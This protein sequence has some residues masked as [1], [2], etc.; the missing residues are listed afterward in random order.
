MGG[1][2]KCDIGFTVKGF[3]YTSIGGVV[4][5]CVRGCLV[6]L[7]KGHVNSISVLTNCI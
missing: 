2:N 5:M 4:V 6:R 3:I 7:P 1:S